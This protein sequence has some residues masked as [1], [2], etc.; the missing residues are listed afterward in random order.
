VTLPGRPALPIWLLAAW[1]VFL[2]AETGEHLAHHVGDADGAATCEV[3]AAATHAPACVAASPGLP[4]LGVA[5][6][7]PPAAVPGRCRALA[8]TTRTARAP[9]GS[10]HPA[11][12]ASFWG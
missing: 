11:P 7:V 5:L 10:R 8:R 6:E 9:P 1:V 3:L 2:A 4:G 12:S